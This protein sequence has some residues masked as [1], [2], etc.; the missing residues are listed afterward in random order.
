MRDDKEEISLLD[1]TP[2]ACLSSSCTYVVR[3]NSYLS[4]TAASWV[5]R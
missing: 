5:L 4:S 1:D 3:M 2:K